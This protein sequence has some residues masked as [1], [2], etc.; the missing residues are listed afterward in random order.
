M[1]KTIQY[2]FDHPVEAKKW[3]KKC[4]QNVKENRSGNQ[5]KPAMRLRE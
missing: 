3:A 5:E 2:V 1:A 4:A